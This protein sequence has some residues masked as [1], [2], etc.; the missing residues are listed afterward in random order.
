M[1]SWAFSSVLVF[2]AALLHLG[3]PRMGGSRV[4]LAAFPA[5]V[6]PLIP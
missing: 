1:N 5:S 6:A 2:L 4:H 3:F